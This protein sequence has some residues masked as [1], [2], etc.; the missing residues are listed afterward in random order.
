MPTFTPANQTSFS[1]NGSTFYCVDVTYDASA[2]SRD[3][4]DMTTLDIA[5]DSEAVMYLSPIKPKRDPRKFSITFYMAAGTALPAEGDQ[6]TLSTADG[7]GEYRCL[8]VS[9]PRKVKEFIQATAEFEEIIT[10]ED[11]FGA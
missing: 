7:S 10:G 4:V 3:R 5:A 9:V 6:G 8:K 11:V 2:P 1:F